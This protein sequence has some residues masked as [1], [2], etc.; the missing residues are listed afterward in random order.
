MGSKRVHIRVGEDRREKWKD[1]ATE[2]FEDKYGSVSKLIRNAVETQIDIDSG[3]LS[4][5]GSTGETTVEPNGRIDDIKV[6][7]E[8]NGSTL[9]DIQERLT[10]IHDDV[11][12]GGMPEPELVFSDVYGELPV[13]EDSFAEAD[14]AA[15]AREF[16]M[17]A[18]EVAE[19]IDMSEDDVGSA[20]IQLYYE[21]DGV[22]M[23]MTREFDS[24]RYWR[25]E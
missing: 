10:K 3:N 7:V 19:K 17:T 11:V 22:E 18:T 5:G 6:T 1:H 24:P 16:G 9:E 14:K 21:Y 2:D 20:L 25:T 23:L 13:V 15:T 4:A 8:D 12:S